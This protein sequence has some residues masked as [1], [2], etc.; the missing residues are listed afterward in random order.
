MSGAPAAIEIIRPP[1]GRCPRFVLFDFDGTLS[2]IR[3]GW[4]DVMVSV[5]VEHLAG[6][7]T[8][9]S[10][11]RLHALAAEDVAE[12]TGEQTIYQ[13]IRLAERVAQF[14]GTPLA[15]HEYK[16]E[17]NRRL[18]EQIAGRRQALASGRIAPDALLVAG[19][20]PLLE[21]LAAR[22]LGMALVSGTDEPYVREEARLLGIDGYFGRH[23]Y[24]ALDDYQ[25]S[26]KGQVVRR[27]LAECGAAGQELLVFGDGFVEI[28]DVKTVGG[29]AVGVASDERSG[30][31]RTC[32]WKRER[33]L[34]AGAD[35][36]VPDY[37]D[38]DRLVTLLLGA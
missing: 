6:L 23:L 26:S 38:H 8:G 33:L 25:A 4:Q 37:A 14:G 24:G 5:M 9:L 35:M 21:A 34:R 36:I 20:R 10:A 1:P 13:M 22:G 17:Y 11:D 3:E 31:G 30:G 12:L 18:L 28:R 7:P 2:L 29:Y 15:P 16:A 27:L 19:S 32:P